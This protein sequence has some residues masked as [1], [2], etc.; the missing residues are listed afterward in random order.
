MSLAA[1]VGGF[2]AAVFVVLLLAGCGPQSGTVVDKHFEPA[3]DET[4][5]RQQW[6][7][8]T[9]SGTGTTRICTPLYIQVPYI[10]HVPDRWSFTLR[11]CGADQDVCQQGKVGVSQQVYDSTDKGDWYE[12]PQ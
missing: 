11:N 6:A 3:H 2:L 12:V 7:G 10:E 4:R 9:C 8:E 1:K 5:F